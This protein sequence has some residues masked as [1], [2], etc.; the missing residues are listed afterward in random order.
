MIFNNYKIVL[1]S[2]LSKRFGRGAYYR[3]KIFNTQRILNKNYPVNSSF[4]FLQVG[5]NDGV[6][7]DFLFDFVVQR[8]IKG[9]VIE[10]I[11]DYYEELCQ[12]YKPYPNVI[13]VH[14][15]VHKDK[16]NI[17]VYKVANSKFE[18]YPDWV[19]GIASFDITNITKFDFIKEEHIEAEQVLAK[20]LMQIVE[21]SKIEAIDYFQID[22]EGYDFEVIQM[23]DFKK[24]KP[25]LIKAEYV[26]LSAIEK[27]MM[28]KLLHTHG[29]YVF[30]EGIDIIGINL[31]KMWL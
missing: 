20:P 27:E 16:S 15:A 26:N 19:K 17:L 29:Y 2:N 14:C 3:K 22:T 28:T 8:Q 25:K 9:V 11:K 13:K 21:E 12:N 23:L 7:F 1:L 31:K 30:F 18:L 6:S 24:L 10:P 5:A 4:S